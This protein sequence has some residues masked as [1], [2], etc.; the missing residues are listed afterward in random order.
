MVQSK[1]SIVYGALKKKIIAAELPPGCPLNEADLA[2]SLG[3]SKTPVREALR[4]LESDGL[5][6][7]IT[8][9]GSAVT[10][11]TMREIDEVF[12]IREII[13]SAAARR[14]ALQHGDPQ[15]LQELQKDRATLD[16]GPNSEEV[17]EEWGTWEGVHIL[18]VKTIGNAILVD[19]YLGLMERITRIRNC[20]KQHFT[21]RRF[22]D[23]LSEHAAILDAIVA[24]DVDLAETNMRRHL[25]RAGVFISELKVDKEGVTS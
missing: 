18:I 10:H 25:Q 2:F 1:T 9:R 14:A 8:S 22:H 20:Y 15:L 4:E 24:G 21:S 7:S 3:V 11:I 17:I 16:R 5:V 12:Q 6:E 19:M 13:E 23:I